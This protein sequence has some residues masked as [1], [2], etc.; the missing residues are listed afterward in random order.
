MY[1]QFLYN[2][3]RLLN[4]KAIS[5]VNISQQQKLKINPIVQ[6]TQFSFWDPLQLTHSP[7][8]GQI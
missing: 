3:D 5:N 7:S 8:Q 6:T 4:K 2:F 1:R